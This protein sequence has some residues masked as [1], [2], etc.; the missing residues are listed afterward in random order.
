MPQFPFS[1]PI[2][3]R[4]PNYAR[5]DILAQDNWADFDPEL[6]R[7]E[8]TVTDNNIASADA[9]LNVRAADGFNWTIELAD[10][11]R[12]E[13]AGLTPNSAANGE[14]VIVLGM[15][16]HH[17]GESRI[18]AVRLTIG[19]QDFALYPELLESA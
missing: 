8:A 17:L 2:A 11:N 10:R 19:E 9:T 3:W 12:N 14:K 1:G 15:R 4:I 5:D 7:L 13:Q 6:T 16:T 18:K